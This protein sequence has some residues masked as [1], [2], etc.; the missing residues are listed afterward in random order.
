MDCNF[1]KGACEW[2]QDKSDDMDWS[3]AYH[4]NGNDV[5]NVTFSKERYS[6]LC[7]QIL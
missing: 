7:I 6:F 4:D 3:V 2:I 5:M 1:D